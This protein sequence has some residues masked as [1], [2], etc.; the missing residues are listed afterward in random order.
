MVFS[1]PVS[2]DLRSGD[3]SEKQHNSVGERAH[4][5]MAPRGQFDAPSA[6]TQ[7]RQ[8]A[9]SS[10]Q[11]PREWRDYDGLDDSKQWLHSD[12]LTAGVL[13]PPLKRLEY[14][15]SWEELIND[16][17][18]QEDRFVEEY[19]DPAPSRKHLGS[20]Y[21]LEK[22][23]DGRQTMSLER[24]GNFG[25]PKWHYR[26]KQTE[27]FHKSKRKRSADVS[28]DNVADPANA[29]NCSENN[30]KISRLRRSISKNVLKNP[31]PAL[32]LE[33]ENSTSGR[34]ASCGTSS[35]GVQLF[36]GCL[37]LKN[38]SAEDAGTFTCRVEFADSPTQTN[39]VNVKV[40]GQSLLSF[41]FE[42]AHFVCI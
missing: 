13:D 12:L 38:I 41:P 25:F 30:Q 21:Q 15:K 35:T 36:P 20:E 8:F 14:S 17:T 2:Y 40:Y 37:Q 3:G 19:S 16:E 24:S 4:F 7:R 5:I 11:T 23:Y 34:D 27:I 32:F 22:Y 18:F 42:L 31:S 9:E 28:L 1:L 39:T 6:S 29:R 10:L 26:R 33:K